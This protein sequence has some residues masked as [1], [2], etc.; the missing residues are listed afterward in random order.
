MEHQRRINEEENKAKEKA[1]FKAQLA[2]EAALRAS[3]DVGSVNG[4]IFEYKE[5]GRFVVHPVVLD[6]N[7]NYVALC[8]AGLLERRRLVSDSDSRWVQAGD[9]VNSWVCIDWFNEDNSQKPKYLEVDNEGKMADLISEVGRKDFEGYYVTE[10]SLSLVEPK[11][12][13]RMK[14]LVV[15]GLN[16]A[17]GMPARRRIK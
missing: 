3:R 4:Y 7:R 15:E 12:R 14:K 13:G 1:E 8:G 16:R 6:D 11:S 9:R 10:Q 17:V 5:S 2:K